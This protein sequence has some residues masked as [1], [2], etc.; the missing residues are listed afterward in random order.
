LLFTTNQTS[1]SQYT[2]TKQPDCRWKRYWLGNYPSQIVIKLNATKSRRF[3][4]WH[5]CC[6]TTKGTDF[7]CLKR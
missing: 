5:I 6:I 3:R 2:G 7:T 1:Q 4:V